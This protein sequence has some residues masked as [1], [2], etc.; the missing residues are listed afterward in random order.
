[1]NNFS[2]ESD[3][4]QKKSQLLIPTQS[5]DLSKDLTTMSRDESK[6]KS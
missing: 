3:T 5:L 1:M 6:V 4:S 2:N